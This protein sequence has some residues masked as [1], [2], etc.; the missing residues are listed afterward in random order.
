MIDLKT[1]Y[2]G[3]ELKNPI[4][5]GASNMVT[6]INMLKRLE[7][8]GAA[9]IVYK[10]LFEEQ[11]QLERLQMEEEA[12]EY[13]ER[14]AEMINLFPKIAHAGPEEFLINLKKACEAVNIPVFASL[15]AVYHNTWV[16]YAVKMEQ[17]GIAGLEL[18]FYAIPYDFNKEAVSIEVEQEQILKA[19]KNA[20]SIP[21]S[22]KLSPFYTN[23]L[24]V[25]NRFDKAGADGIVLFNRLFQP[26]FDLDTD[27]LVFPYNLS[28]EADNKIRIR[29]AGLLYGNINAGICTGGGITNGDD[30]IKMILAGADSVQVVSAIYRKGPEYISEMLKQ[31]EERMLI[32]G[33]KTLDDFRGK[34]S[35][36]NTTD[37][38]A[39]KRAQYVD[40]LLNSEEIFRRYPIA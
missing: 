20:V 5:I 29:F 31:I 24:N 30:I 6:D 22:V 2:L 10:S 3:V 7:D 40:I 33:Y 28:S 13:T 32:K 15:N 34:F 37:I 21:V 8:A 35:K 39:Y 12:N 4:I 19:V 14:H 18:N 17:T 27:K 16:D 25:I 11:I 23:I 26:D 9:A 1:K 38:F 36:K